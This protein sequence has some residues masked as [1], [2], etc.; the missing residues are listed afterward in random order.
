MSNPVAPKITIDRFPRVKSEPLIKLKSK[1]TANLLDPTSAHYMSRFDV[2]AHATAPR[3]GKIKYRISTPPSHAVSDRIQPVSDRIQGRSRSAPTS[4]SVKI[5]EE[6]PLICRILEC[7]DD[8]E[9]RK[10][11]YTV[12]V[13]YYKLCKEPKLCRQYRN[14]LVDLMPERVKVEE[15]TSLCNCIGVLFEKIII[16]D[17]IYTKMMK[18]ANEKEEYNGRKVFFFLLNLYNDLENQVVVEILTNIKKVN[19]TQK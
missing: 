9:K 15:L 4:L 14:C 12:L 10:K 8:F 17:A 11:A 16:P 5:D 3:E 7:R 6:D 19:Q 1:Q 2:T 18:Y 13:Q